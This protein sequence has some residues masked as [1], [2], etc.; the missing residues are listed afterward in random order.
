[1]SVAPTLIAEIGKHVDSEVEIA[2]WLYNLRSKGKI[3]FLQLR[4]GSGRLQAVAVQGECDPASFAAIGELKMEASLKVRGRVRPEERAPG[5]YEL[6]VIEGAVV[7]NPIEDFPIAKKE[8]GI[9]FLLE[10]R[11]LW[12]RSSLPGAILK[13][14]HEAIASL[15]GL[16]VDQPRNLAKSVTV[17]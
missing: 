7:Q 8:H 12:L 17:E 9:D 4:D 15:R 3:H 16:D 10:N 1:M 13:V 14:R 5:G 2:G 6:A 11:H